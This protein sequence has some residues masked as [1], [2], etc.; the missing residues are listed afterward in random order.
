M[1]VTVFLLSLVCHGNQYMKTNLVCLG[2][3]Q[4]ASPIPL[5]PDY[6]SHS[7]FSES[8]QDTALVRGPSALLLP[9]WGVEYL[10]FKH[11]KCTKFNTECCRQNMYHKPLLLC[12]LTLEAKEL[13]KTPNNI[14]SC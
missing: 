11:Q 3:R 14:V 7:G 13:K 10:I 12:Y 2:N 9:V 4:L 1:V 6:T 8:M 5:L